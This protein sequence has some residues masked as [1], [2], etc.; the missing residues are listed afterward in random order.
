MKCLFRFFAIFKVEL[1]VFLLLNCRD[2][3]YFE[4][5]CLPKSYF[6]VLFPF[7]NLFLLFLIES[8]Q[9]QRFLILMKPKLFFLLSRVFILYV[10]KH[11]LIHDTKYL[12][13]FYFKSFI[14]L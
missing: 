3:L 7:Y 4:Y 13:L 11:C 5:S 10:R 6:Q 9:A 1:G 8:F 12:S 14:V 2:L